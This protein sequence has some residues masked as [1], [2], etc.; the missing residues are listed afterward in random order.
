VFVL[1]AIALSAAGVFYA[2]R[3]LDS[4]ER[5]DLPSLTQ[6]GKSVQSAGL[7]PTTIENYLLVG[8]DSRAGAN[9]DDEDAG[10]I[11]NAQE[12]TGQRSDTIMILRFDPSNNSSTLL[13][14]PRDL[15]VPI[16]GT[17]GKDKINSAFSKSSDVLINTI[18]NDF[19]IPIHHYVEVGFEGFKSLVDAI[20]GVTVNFPEPARDLKTGFEVLTPG[21]NTLD[22]TQALA[23]ARSRYYE[24]F[25]NGKWRQDPSSDLGRIA[26]QQDFLKQAFA[27]ALATASSNPLAANQLIS[28]ALNDIKIDKTLDL[29][30]L[31]NRLRKLGSGGVKSWTLPASLGTVGNQSVLFVDNAKAQPIIDFFK[32]TGP[33]PADPGATPGNA[34][35]LGR[36]AVAAQTA[37]GAQTCS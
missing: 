5:V 8:S 18:Q 25:T 22:G 24:T 33:E 4:V 11:G 36:A 6:E 34:V 23:F 21:C 1:T 20:G 12:V 2:K 15:W 16:A 29:F 26:R 35:P 32:G 10:A 30:G 27:K 31:A 13:S 3:T 9:P 37:T 17:N 14:L 7:G 28:A 19:G